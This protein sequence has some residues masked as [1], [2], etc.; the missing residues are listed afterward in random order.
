MFIISGTA[1]RVFETVDAG[2]FAFLLCESVLPDGSAGPE[3]WLCLV[4]RAFYGAV[5]ISRSEGVLAWPGE[6]RFTISSRNRV[7]FRPEVV[8][9]AHVFTCEEAGLSSFCDDEFRDACRTARLKGPGFMKR[10]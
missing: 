7:Y 6:R 3:T 4:T 8:G 5:D 10:F 2:A 9:A 1:K